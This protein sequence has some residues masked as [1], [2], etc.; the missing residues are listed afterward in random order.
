MKNNPFAILCGDLSDLLWEKRQAYGANNLTG[1]GDFFKLLFPEG[2]PPERY[3]DAL[4]LAR[5]FDKMSRIARGTSG[6]EDAWQDLA[7]YAVCA[8]E[9]RERLDDE[10]ACGD[11]GLDG[12][13][14]GLNACPGCHPE[15]L[16]QK[17]RKK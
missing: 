16:G 8:M 10:W 7:G 17:K 3:Q 15:H 1:T 5:M 12:I 2:I 13:A 4:I 11:C 14:A 9:L 6:K